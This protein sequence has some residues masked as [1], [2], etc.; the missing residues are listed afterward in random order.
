MAATIL[1]NASYPWD[2]EQLEKAGIDDE[3]AIRMARAGWLRIDVDGRYEVPHE[4]LLHFAIA[5]H[6][7]VRHRNRT[8]DDAELAELFAAMLIGSKQF[9]GLSLGYVPMDWFF[10]RT[11]D[12]G[13]ATLAVFRGVRDRLDHDMREALHRDLLPTLGAAALPLLW[14]SLV[15]IGGAGNRWEL[16]PILDG[17]AKQPVDAVRP[18]AV[19]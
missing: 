5:K 8:I 14:D 11:C 4:R 15:A 2:D 12:E 10:L 7:A 3:A 6:F 13:G 17:I 9:S 1:E 19:R 16:A 18:L